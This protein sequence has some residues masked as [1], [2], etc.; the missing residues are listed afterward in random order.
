MQ[1]TVTCQGCATQFSYEWAKP[2]KGGQMRRY[3]DGCVQQHRRQWRNYQPIARSSRTCEQCGSA[4][5]PYKEDSTQ[6]TCSPKCAE[7]NRKRDWFSERLRRHGLSRERY[8]AMVVN[9]CGICGSK[10]SGSQGWWHIDH[11]HAHCPGSYGCATCVRGLLC[12]MCN[13]GLGYF[14][15]DPEIMRAAI[16]YIERHNAKAT[17]DAH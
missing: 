17:Q 8:D 14:R 11:D 13:P 10:T 5:F 12:Q 3:C 9:G 1:K 2:R 6:A 4:F 7:R 15:D 16:S